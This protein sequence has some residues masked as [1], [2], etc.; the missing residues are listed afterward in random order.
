MVFLTAGFAPIFPRG[1]S[2]LAFV[3][4]LGVFS[5]SHFSGK[6]YGKPAVEKHHTNL[7]NRM[8]VLRNRRPPRMHPGCAD[9]LLKK[10]NRIQRAYYD[11]LRTIFSTAVASHYGGP[12]CSP[13]LWWCDKKH[14]QVLEPP[15][16]I[17][18][19][20]LPVLSVLNIGSLHTEPPPYDF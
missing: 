18:M 12:R 9:P 10:K 3:H 4:P 15:I 17:K 14:S 6:T 20:G 19:E 1:P 13:I 7:K 2:S 16:Y 8:A 5:S 11:H